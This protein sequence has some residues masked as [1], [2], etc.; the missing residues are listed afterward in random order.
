MEKLFPICGYTRETK[1]KYYKSLYKNSAENYVRNN[2]FVCNSNIKILSETSRAYCKE[3][4]FSDEC[5][6]ALKDMANIKSPSVDGLTAEFCKFVWVDIKYVVFESIKYS[7]NKGTLSVDQRT[8][9][10]SLT[11][12]KAIDLRHL[13]YWHTLT[14]LNA[15]YKILA[16]FLS[17]RL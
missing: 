10:V 16:K 8:G 3:E 11:P 13:K 14:L 12:K 2:T 4:S 15:D 6:K 17:A 5:L 9:L 7:L 1:T